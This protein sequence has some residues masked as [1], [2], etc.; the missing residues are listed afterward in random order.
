MS[1]KITGLDKL[2]KDLDDAQ[3]ALRSL[4]GTIAT[5]KYDPN[6]PASVQQAIRQMESSIE[7]KISPWRNNQMVSKIAASLKTQYRQAILKRAA[8]QRAPREL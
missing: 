7:S 3:R 6:E 2:L 1:I 5:L 8:E 4:D